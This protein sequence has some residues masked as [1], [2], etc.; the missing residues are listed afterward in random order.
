MNNK[1]YDKEIIFA[2]NKLI[3]KANLSNPYLNILLV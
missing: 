3:A 2:D 1:I